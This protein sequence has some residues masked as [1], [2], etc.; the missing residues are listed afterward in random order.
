MNKPRMSQPLRSTPI[1]DASSLLQAGP[2]ACPHRY[3]APRSFCCPVHSLSPRLHL[4]GEDRS[5]IGTRLPTF[6][7]VAADQARAAFTPDTAWPVNG[8]PPDSSRGFAHT[9]VLMPS[10]V[11]RRFINGSLTLAFLIPA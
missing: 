11:F 2:P 3:S 7:V 9:P 8:H 1:T 10:P 5:S 6:H 4:F